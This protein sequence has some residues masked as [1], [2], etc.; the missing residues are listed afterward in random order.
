MFINQILDRS[1]FINQWQ[2]LFFQSVFQTMLVCQSA[3]NFLCLAG[4]S[5]LNEKTFR[6][7]FGK[8]FCF[9]SLN[10]TISEKCQ[11][12]SPIAVAGDA[13]F[14]KK[15]GKHT[16]GLD[17]FWNGSHW[18]VEKGSKLSI[19]AFI[20]QPNNASPALSAAQTPPHL[21]AAETDKNRLTR[22]DFYLQHFLETVRLF[23]KAVEY[24][25]VDGFY[26]KLK[27]VNGVS[28]NGFHLISKL[29]T[30]ANLQ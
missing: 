28:L 5:N 30:N 29:R 21:A 15:S 1:H 26:A 13:W 14:I 16:F 8:H 11:V 19:I 17:K 7:N 23:P 18:R 12:V 10:G 9:A 22:I 2:R 25:L 3:I 24:L 4:H 20:D 6:P 27:F